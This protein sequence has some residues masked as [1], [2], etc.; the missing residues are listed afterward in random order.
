MLELIL[1]GNKKNAAHVNNYGSV[2]YTFSLN[3]ESDLYFEETD[4]T[5]ANQLASE[6]R[7]IKRYHNHSQAKPSNTLH[8]IVLVRGSESHSAYSTGRGLAARSILTCRICSV[9]II[10]FIFFCAPYEL[11]FCEKEMH[12]ILKSFSQKKNP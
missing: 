3:K 4:E 10:F 9:E 5:T 6:A 2:I 12:F 7:R 8:Y 11:F 1:C